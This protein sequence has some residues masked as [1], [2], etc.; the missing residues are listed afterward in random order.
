MP[1]V[2]ELTSSAATP[3]AASTVLNDELQAALAGDAALIVLAANTSVAA[4]EA[5]VAGLDPEQVATARIRNPLAA[6]LS[7]ERAMLQL[8]PEDEGDLILDDAGRLVRAVTAR[9]S[10][11]P[12]LLVIVEQAETLT[13]SALALLQILPDI[14]A[15]G[16]GRVRVVFHG[17]TKF[18]ALLEDPR[19]HSIRD[20]E[21][22]PR[23]PA[24]VTP[25]LGLLPASRLQGTGRNILVATAAAALVIVVAVVLAVSQ[26][27]TER[28]PTIKSILASRPIEMGGSTP[29]ALLRDQASEPVPQAIASVP[30]ISPLA[31]SAPAPSGSPPETFT[32][33]VSVPTVAEEPA[34]ARARVFHEFNTF[35][36]ATG[37]G[38]RLSRSDRETLFQEY[39]VRRQT[40]AARA[41]A[42]IAGSQPGAASVQPE[43]V[44]FF[45]SSAR[46]AEALAEREAASLRERMPNVILRPSIDDIPNPTVSYFRPEDRDIALAI[47]TMLPPAE[48]WTVV[49]LSGA[50][51]EPAP[52]IIEIRV[53]SPPASP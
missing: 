49:N 48:D 36:K 47:T 39:L 1:R 42:L 53:P 32:P 23:A 52:A 3:A 19:F 27:P 12:C 50:P 35:L 4:L 30:P 31:P 20:S 13:S 51:S 26:S 6:Q 46:G 9:A 10:G 33:S 43:I 40:A 11:R 45:Q 2:G 7:V 15:P 37:R 29:P 34:A 5:A 16:V 8:A 22:A 38:G 21:I 25:Q 44:L 24:T 41:S 14:Q 17:T 28:P 18:R